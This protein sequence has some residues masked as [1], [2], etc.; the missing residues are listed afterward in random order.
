MSSQIKTLI[1]GGG[2][3]LLLIGITV[4]LILTAPKSSTT[5]EV[6]TTAPPKTRLL[7]EIAPQN[8][9]TLTVSNES[10][11]L[12]IERVDVEDTFIFVTEEFLDLPLNFERILEIAESACTQTASEVLA[13]NADD[14]SKYGL[15]SPQATF[16]AVF[17]DS[18]GTVKKVLIGDAAPDQV[19]YYAAFEGENTV[20]LISTSSLEIFTEDRLDIINK[21]LYKEVTP[22]SED[23]TTDYKQVSDLIINRTDLPYDVE[24]KF[25][26]Y[27]LENPVPAGESSASYV[28]ASPVRLDINLSEA[29]SVINSIFGLTADGIEKLRPAPEDLTAYGFD[30]PMTT[31]SFSLIDKSLTLRVGN[32]Y[33]GGRYVMVDGV[34]IIWKLS[35]S[36][37]P[38]VTVKPLSITIGI[39]LSTNIYSISTFDITGSGFNEHITSSG[40]NADDMTVTL[41]GEEVDAV[42]LRL[43]YQYILSAPP[44]EIYIEPLTGEPD[45]SIAIKGDN[46]NKNISFYNLGDRR[47]AISID[48]KPQFVCSQTYY[49]RLI[50][51]INAFKSGEEINTNR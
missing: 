7:Y 9:K 25:N 8:L 6:I 1:A 48:G 36:K 26:P 45:L 37:L 11:D 49:D 34:N 30:E 31:V 43:L 19:N 13:E 46:L 5:D 14:L 40:N 39:I 47:Y 44:A 18:K 23:D 20:Y 21:T 22:A 33:D 24:I 10:G 4:A 51:N 50:E 38:W 16:T 28:L 12:L 29:D 15:T 42:S 41:N 35:D 2:I 32:A 27:S 3:L 17:D